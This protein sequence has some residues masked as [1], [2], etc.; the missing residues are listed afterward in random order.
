MLRMTVLV[1]LA[2]IGSAAAL[3]YDLN[4]PLVASGTAP[5]DPVPPAPAPPAPATAA[6]SGAVAIR[7]I[8]AMARVQRPAQPPPAP[9][10]EPRDIAKMRCSE[11]REMSAGSGRV[12][13][14]D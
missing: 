6:S 1:W 7:E 12:Q 9:L 10:R 14:C 2:A 13:I 5:P 3:T 8:K 11:W 4:R